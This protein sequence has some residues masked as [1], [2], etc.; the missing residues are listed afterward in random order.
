MAGY[1][2]DKDGM[3]TCNAVCTQSWVYMYMGEVGC[4]PSYRV[5]E[6]YR[7]SCA[8]WDCFSAVSS[9]Y[10]GNILYVYLSMFVKVYSF[11]FFVGGLL[12]FFLR[13]PSRRFSVL[14]MWWVIVY[15][16]SAYHDDV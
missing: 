16:Y 9:S 6:R 11:F 12:V 15:A 8:T 13:A 1:A 3:C 10:A 7:T 5:L 4:Y 14:Y 2:G